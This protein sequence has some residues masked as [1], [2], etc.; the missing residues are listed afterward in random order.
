MKD[1]ADN[2]RRREKG[3]LIQTSKS[4]ADYAFPNDETRHQRCE[5]AADYDICT[6]TNDSCQFINC[7]CL[8]RKCTACNSIA[9]PGVEID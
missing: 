5:N 6:P 1:K 4:Y 7:E 8:L 3:E 9:I 2:S